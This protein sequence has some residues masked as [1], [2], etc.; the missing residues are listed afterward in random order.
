MG[1][2]QLA[3]ILTGMD[4]SFVVLAA[5][6]KVLAVESFL[7]NLLWNRSGENIEGGSLLVSVTVE[8][9]YFDVSVLGFYP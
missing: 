8:L 2:Q 5:G 3:H 9:F 1:L 6:T 4:I 7:Q